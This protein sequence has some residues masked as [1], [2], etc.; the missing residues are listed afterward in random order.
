VPGALLPEVRDSAGDFGT[1]A[2][3]VLGRAI[4]LR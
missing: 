3:E 4:P 2:P 1:S